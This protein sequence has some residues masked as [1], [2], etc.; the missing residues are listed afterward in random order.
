MRGTPVRCVYASGLAHTPKKGSHAGGTFILAKA[1]IPAVARPAKQVGVAWFVLSGRHAPPAGGPMRGAPGVV[2]SVLSGRHTP[3]A[4]GPMR[5]APRTVC[6]CFRA[7][8]LL[9]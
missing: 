8:T 3:P 5:G 1:Q 7:G 9:H 4:G 2:W 6:L